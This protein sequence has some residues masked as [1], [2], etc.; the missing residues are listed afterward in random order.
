MELV[1]DLR[2]TL[3]LSRMSRSSEEVIAL[4]EDVERKVADAL[5]AGHFALH[6]LVQREVADALEAGLPE[7]RDGRCPCGYCEYVET[8]WCEP[9]FTGPRE[10]DWQPYPVP[11]HWRKCPRC[12]A[13]LG[14]D[15]VARRNASAARVER[16][17]AALEYQEKRGTGDHWCCFWGNE[18]CAAI[19]SALDGPVAGDQPEQ[20]TG[21]AAMRGD[22]ADI[23]RV[24]LLE[25]LMRQSAERGEC[26]ILDGRNGEAVIHWWPETASDEV[27]MDVSFSG[28]GLR[29]A[30]DKAKEGERDG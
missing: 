25:E 26:V 27:P 17:R 16:V 13:E 29:A 1:A 6:V 8:V 19:R 9:R 22:A 2:R 21:F 11:K 18:V 15:G 12:G 30:L 14:A 24:D 4:H 28:S 23:E 7:E 10:D 20:P 3:H 5:E